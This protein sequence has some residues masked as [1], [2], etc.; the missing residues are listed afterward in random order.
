MNLIR[1]A[2]VRRITFKKSSR[3]GFTKACINIPVGYFMHADPRSMLLLM[4]RE[5]SAETHS[6]VELA[7][8]LRDVEPL[9][10]LVIDNTRQTTSTILQKHYPGGII[11][12]GGA[13]SSRVFRQLTV[14]IAFCDETSDYPHSSGGEGNALKLAERRMGD[15]WNRILIEGSTPKIKGACAISDSY[16]SSDKRRYLVPCPR[17]DAGQ[18]LEWGGKEFDFGI[19][20]PK[21]RP[22]EAHYLCRHCHQQI[23]H[24]EK[25]WMVEQGH[26]QVTQPDG[27]WPGFHIWAVYSFMPDADWGQLAKEFL[28]AGNDPQKLQVFEN[29]IK[30]EAFEELGRAPRE[31]KLFARR[32]KYPQRETG[33]LTIE[34]DRELENMVPKAAGVLTAG[35]DVHPDRLE[36]Q[37]IAWGL[38]EEAWPLD[39]RILYGDPTALPIWDA[40]FEQ[41]CRPYHLEGGGVDFIR[42]TCIDSGYATQS[43][44]GFTAP[45]SSYYTADGNLGFLWAIKGSDGPGRLWPSAPGK[46]TGPTKAKV[47]TIKVDAAKDALYGRTD[48]I[49]EPGPRYVHFPDTLDEKYFRQ[50]TAEQAMHA[51]NKRGYLVRSYQM[52]KGRQRNEALDTAVYAYAALWALYEM[53]GLD[54][55]LAC[56]RAHGV[57]HLP[58]EDPPDDEGPQSP[59][60]GSPPQGETSR[61]DGW[62]DEKRGRWVDRRR[63]W[64]R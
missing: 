22:A 32:E 6:K 35:T 19:K 63:D 54:L 5:A 12:L 18:Y 48:S 13:N 10:G 50:F 20:W 39:Y 45:R 37:V 51:R 17:C 40:Y 26:Y 53:H 59:P 49:D 56:K 4:P 23:E 57:Y 29:T 55:E 52:K 58:G 46:T 64:I 28:E 24:R 61:R 44:Y 21:D 47:W 3:V 30:G 60:D 33:R 36:T 34:G 27:E 14:S 62:A 15:A 41:I 25:R 9:R 1:D 2:T 7:P 42:S 11:H 38:E 31:G 43:V 8:M 16:E